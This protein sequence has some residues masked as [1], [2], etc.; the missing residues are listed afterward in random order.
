M[1]ITI[2]DLARMAN[3]STATVSRVLS[4]KPGVAEAKRKSIIQLAEKVGYTPNR[5]AQNLALKKSHV[6]GMIA[7][8]LSNPV[9]VEFF[10]YIQNRLQEQ[11]YQVLISDSALDVERER[12]NI[13]TMREN[14]VEGVIVFPVHDW[15]QKTGVEQFLQL[16][17][18]KFPFVVVGKIDGYGFDSVTDEEVETS[19][20]LT[21]HLIE[22]GHKRI[23][24]VG[25]D[26]ENRCVEERM[27]GFTLALEE[28]GID[29][30]SA[31][32]IPIE[33][34]D[35][36]SYEKSLRKLLEREDRP[37]ALVLVNDIWALVT[38][39]L[40]RDLG[41]EM[42]EDVALVSFGDALWNRHVRPPVTS[43]RPR[44]NEVAYEA[45]EM[46]MRR[47]ENPE[48]TSL[49]KTVPQEVIFR[50]SS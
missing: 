17:L 41:Y 20:V 6:L 22:R 12:R 30:A 9:Y 27:K 37:T 3:T 43:T 26:H 47:I 24:F 36:E 25:C 1:T 2:K 16:K 45:L 19:K 44:T 46:L 28:A 39:H 13:A 8:D 11:G 33:G 32:V 14:R 42:P 15:H 21:R 29:S 10:R 5:I 49:Q 35:E 4:G 48:I 38:H 40:L 7:A 50:E 31:P 18:Q 34:P 23:A